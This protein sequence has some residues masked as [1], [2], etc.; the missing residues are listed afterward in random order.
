M[1]RRTFLK[2]AVVAPA[3]S[4]GAPPPLGRRRTR[5]SI[6]GANFL[7]NGKLTYPGRIFRGHNIEGLLLNTRMVQGIFDDKNPTTRGKWAY[8]DTGIWDPERN[9]NEFIAA[10]PAWRDHGVLCF[11]INLQGGSP[12]GYS[13]VQPW[14]TSGI[15]PDGDLR[16]S[17]LA[18][19]EKILDRA[20]QLGMAPIVG[21][22]YFGQDQRVKDEAAVIRSVKLA[23]RWILSHGY[24]NVLLE[25]ANECDVKAYDHEI[26]KPGRVHELIEIAK[27]TRVHGR[28]LLTGVSYGGGSIPKRTV[29]QSSDFLLLHGNGVSDPARIAEM[30]R[31][32]RRVEG[33]R[34]VP[35][36][37]NE[38]DHFN[39]DQ[40]SNNM[41]AAIGEYASW[42][43]FD[44]GKSDY[45]DGY[46]CPP[47]NWNINTARK[48]AFFGFAK[49]VAGL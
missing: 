34:P 41:M 22:Y 1:N 5:V 4:Q 47:V 49:E 29:V 21:L 38:D 6:S 46:Q 42:G 2:A 35:I 24:R 40:P 27:A 18:R 48:Q 20:D 39:F 26:L 10:M 43:Y 23:A 16:P 44:P 8:P 25:I 15:D 45:S 17:Y 13:K 9:T 3:L 31:E 28:R 33:Y 19:L 36:L 30:V 12:E 32:T 37:F 14:D 11:T 7:I